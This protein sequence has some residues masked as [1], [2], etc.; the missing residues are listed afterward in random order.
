MEPDCVSYN[1]KKR[2]SGNYGTHKC[3]LNDAT[4]EGHEEDLV[5]NASYIY[6]GVEASVTFNSLCSVNRVKTM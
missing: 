1:L 2:P 6:R 4:H 5:K 3:E